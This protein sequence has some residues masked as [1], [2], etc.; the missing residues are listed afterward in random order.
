MA[1]RALNKLVPASPSSHVGPHC[2]FS[3]AAGVFS[4]FNKFF[5]TSG[6]LY[7]LFLLLRILFPWLFAALGPSPLQVSFLRH[8]SSLPPCTTLCL[9]LLAPPYTEHNL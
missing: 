9:C 4:L 1:C 7:L 8:L 3:S 5:P 2:S 6:P